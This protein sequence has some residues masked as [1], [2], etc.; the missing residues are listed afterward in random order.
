V[1]T[2]TNRRLS[3]KEYTAKKDAKEAEKKS[4]TYAA[5]QEFIDAMNS[6]YEAEEQALRSAANTAES[7]A[8]PDCKGVQQETTYAKPALT[9]KMSAK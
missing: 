8:I 3:G 5:A 9:K 6:K 2:P 7:Q 4:K 1:N